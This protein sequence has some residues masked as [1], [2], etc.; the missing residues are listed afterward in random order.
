MT[1]QKFTR[2]VKLITVCA[3]CLLFCLVC[4]VIGQSIK[5]N[6]LKKQ[7]KDLDAQISA[8]AVQ[9]Q[10]LNEGI[11][12]RGKNAYLEEQA[13][14]RLGMIQEGEVLYIYQ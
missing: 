3:T 13:R 4:V 7:E 14:E 1:Q 9:Q 12:Y 10:T 6:N 11:D 2:L 5:L 8:L